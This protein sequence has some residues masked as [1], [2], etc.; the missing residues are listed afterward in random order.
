M[1]LHFQNL[2]S[3]CPL[4]SLTQHSLY[5]Q[6]NISNI[7]SVEHRLPQ[8]QKL[9]VWLDNIWEHQHDSGFLLFSVALLPA[10]WSCQSIWKGSW[11]V[12]LLCYNYITLLNHFQKE[13]QCSN[14][15][16]KYLA[17][18]KLS[19]IPFEMR[20]LLCW[21]FW[22]LNVQLQGGHMFRRGVPWNSDEYQLRS[23]VVNILGYCWWVYEAALPIAL[24]DGLMVYSK[25]VV[26][27]LLC[28]REFILLYV[29]FQNTLSEN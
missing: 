15:M 28:L 11:F 22:C 20:V 8:N 25:L 27:L 3:P 24:C 14:V 29:C 21:Q 19:L 23:L 4:L 10:G 2:L 7:F 12:S 18:N 9:R 17:H 16:V 6:I 5:Y 1:F 13:N 26:W